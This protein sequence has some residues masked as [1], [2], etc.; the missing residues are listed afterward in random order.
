M[1]A[2]ILESVLFLQ[3]SKKAGCRDLGWWEDDVGNVATG[4]Q[5]K[6]LSRGSADDTPP[7]VIRAP[8]GTVSHLLDC[9]TTLPP[10]P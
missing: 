6:K 5:A 7:E 4:C 1:V 10:Q 9:I 2:K 3:K 8:T